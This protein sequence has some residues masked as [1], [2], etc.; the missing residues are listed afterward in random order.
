MEK[1]FKDLA[2]CAEQSWVREADSKKE[3]NI[4]GGI[5]INLPSQNYLNFFFFASV[6]GDC[7]FFSL[8]Q[9]QKVLFSP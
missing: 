9:M 7:N 5:C 4:A 2:Y 6:K 1:T 3:G 8:P